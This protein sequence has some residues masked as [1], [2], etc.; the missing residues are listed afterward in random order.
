MEPLRNQMLFC[1]GQ[2]APYDYLG[3]AMYPE[4]EHTYEP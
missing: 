4:T 2:I 3:F 1:L